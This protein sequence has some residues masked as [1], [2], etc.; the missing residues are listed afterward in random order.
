MESGA[1]STVE[2]PESMTDASHASLP[3]EDISKSD[4]VDEKLACS[5]AVNSQEWRAAANA[6]KLAPY[7]PRTNDGNDCD[8]KTTN[9]AP[10]NGYVCALCSLT[11]TP[12]ISRK[13]NMAIPQK[14]PN[15]TAPAPSLGLG[16]PVSWVIL[17]RTLALCISATAE[18]KR[19]RDSPPL[20]AGDSSVNTLGIINMA[21]KN[22][23]TTNSQ[24]IP[25]D[26]SISSNNESQQAPKT[27]ISSQEPP[28]AQRILRA[29]E[30]VLAGLMRGGRGWMRREC[31]WQRWTQA[32]A[33]P[34]DGSSGSGEGAGAEDGGGDG[35]VKKGKKGKKIDT[36][37]DGK[38]AVAVKEKGKGK[39]KKNV[40]AGASVNA[41]SVSLS[42]CGSVCGRDGVKCIGE[43]I[44]NGLPKAVIQQNPQQNS[45]T[46]DDSV[47][48]ERLLQRLANVIASISVAL[49]KYTPLGGQANPISQNRPINE[50]Q[51][52][53]PRDR[54][55][56]GLLP[57]S[58]RA[59]MLKY[60]V[61]RIF[62]F[63][64]Q[65]DCV[66]LRNSLE[67]KADSSHP[68]M[69]PRW[70]RMA[71]FIQILN[72]ESRR[73]SQLGILCLSETPPSA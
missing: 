27:P 60:S 44:N 3:S 68:H 58:H 73:Q 67:R 8:G 13:V 29:V 48:D 32:T 21:L 69:N 23:G 20:P 15:I 18:A 9:P 45:K 71:S 34:S 28:P 54:P 59:A 66:K 53:S 57:Q 14:Q 50:S 35:K 40:D 4:A 26:A 42:G 17:G 5:C 2:V 16:G 62:G 37:K 12:S 49:P 30:M 41:D 70:T 63:D 36:K 22:P 33:G 52:L 6:V 19:R 56:S 46:G 51:S 31:A 64:F 72:R 61:S 24:K 43:L 7:D 39:D 11:T 47:R 38:D 25:V 55:T 65:R 10:G 1:E